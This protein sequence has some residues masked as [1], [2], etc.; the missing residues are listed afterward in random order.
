MYV[1]LSKNSKHIEYMKN[2]AYPKKKIYDLKTLKHI[3]YSWHLKGKKV[4]FTNGCFD[5]LHK[6]HLKSL[7]D[8][9]QEADYLIVAINSDA[10]VKRLK[11]SS[12]PINSEMDRAEMIASLLIVDAVVI[13]DEDTP[14]NVIKVLQPNVLVKGGDYAFNDIVGAKEVIENGGEVIIN[15]LV[16]GYSTTNIIDKIKTAI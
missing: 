5:I 7:S 12:R 4:A 2:I 11:G 6:G 8:A 1:Y 15:S 16:D 9:A 3:M 13:F 14:E 10:S